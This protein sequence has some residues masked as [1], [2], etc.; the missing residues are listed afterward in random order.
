MITICILSRWIKTTS[1]QFSSPLVPTH[2]M[3]RWNDW[4]F[5]YLLRRFRTSSC[6]NSSGFVV[7]KTYMHR[8]TERI[9]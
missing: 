1:P 6:V 2:K 9:H 5:F 7:F 4:A 8:V 3:H